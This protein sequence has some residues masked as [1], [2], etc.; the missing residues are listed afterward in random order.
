MS[1]PARRS[2]LEPGQ[3]SGQMGGFQAEDHHE[4]DSGGTVL[5]GHGAG[6]KTGPT[7]SFWFCH[8]G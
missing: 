8:S 7:S 1:N 6:A 4:K 5:A 3:M 2:D